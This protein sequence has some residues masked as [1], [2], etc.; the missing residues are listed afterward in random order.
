[1]VPT[2]RFCCIDAAGQLNSMLGRTV[3]HYQRIVSLSGGLHLDRHVVGRNRDPRTLTVYIV[4]PEGHVL[5]AT[6]GIG[7]RAWAGSN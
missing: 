6:I 7:P 5:G 2:A 3:G 4:S 1:M